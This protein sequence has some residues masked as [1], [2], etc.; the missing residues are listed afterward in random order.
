MGDAWCSGKLWVGMQ[1]CTSVAI[2]SCWEGFKKN[3]ELM[4]SLQ[5]KI[6]LKSWHFETLCPLLLSHLDV[7]ASK[8]KFTISNVALLPTSAPALS[9]TSGNPKYPW[10][11]TLLF[12]AAQIHAPSAS[13]SEGRAQGKPRAAEFSLCFEERIMAVE[14]ESN[15]CRECTN[16]LISQQ[17]WMPG[18]MAMQSRPFGKQIWS[19]DDRGG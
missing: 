15:W 8:L 1:M 18:F 5:L 7:W 10:S 2:Y 12:A 9:K 17:S 14:I 19:A 3:K 4:V 16:K 13:K 6:A 11:G